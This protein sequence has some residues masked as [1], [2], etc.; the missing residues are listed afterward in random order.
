MKYFEV[1]GIFQATGERGQKGRN[2]SLHVNKTPIVLFWKKKKNKT[3]T[4]HHRNNSLYA[5]REVG[6]KQFVQAL[7]HLLE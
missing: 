1:F 6:R 3:E 5:K 7:G 2:E 4:A